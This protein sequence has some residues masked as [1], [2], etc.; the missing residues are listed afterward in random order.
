MALLF[1]AIGAFVY[2]LIIDVG[3]LEGHKAELLQ[4]PGAFLTTVFAFNVFGFSAARVYNYWNRHIPSFYERRWL[5]G[6][7]FIPVGIYLLVVHFAVFWFVGWLVWTEPEYIFRGRVLRLIFTTWFVEMI[8]VGLLF[9]NISY[10]HMLALHREKERLKETAD[11]AQ[12]RAL[13]NQLNPHFLFNSLNTLVAEIQYDPQN[14][15]KFVQKLSDVYRYVLQ[16]DDKQVV[17]LREE[18]A[19]LQ[20]YLFLHQVRIGDCLTI[21]RNLP[22]SVLKDGKLPSLTLQLLME[23]VLKHNCIGD[24]MPMTIH[25]DAVDGGRAISFRNRICPKQETAPS[26]KGLKNLSERYK[27][28]CGQDIEV[29]SSNREFTVII[30]L[31]YE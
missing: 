3:E 28:L 2:L 14:A 29:R 22:E 4:T 12:Y 20:S 16:Q 15:V 9:I 11:K 24:E 25:I 10:N 1:S 17:S 27:L 8:I 30:P 26:G 18:L 6:W 13:Q 31:I 23:N 21:E 19:F 5:L 7:S